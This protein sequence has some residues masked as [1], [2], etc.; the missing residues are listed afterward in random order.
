MLGPYEIL[1]RI[2]AGGMG[3]VF[4]ARDTR[5]DRIV[6]IKRLKPE[7]AERFKR[8]ARAIAQLNHPHICQ[9]YDVGEDYLVMEF[10]DG[11]PLPSRLP[12]EDF[13]KLAIQIAAALEEAHTKGI[14]H[15]DLKPANILVAA[16]GAKLL[17]FGLA[18]F[19]KPLPETT[20]TMTQAG[21][22]V[23][24]VAYMSPEQAQ[25]LPIDTRSD[26]FSLGAVLYEACSGSR[27]F[28]GETALATL[29][30]IIRDDP[31]DLE[32]SPSLKRIIL[33]CLAKQTHARYQTM[34]DLRSALEQLVRA[35][36]QDTQ[37]SIAVL[38]FANMSPEADEYFSDGLAEEIINLLAHIP[39]LKVTARTSAF[40]FR[41]KEQ[42]IRKIADA[43]GVRAILEGSVRR[44]GNR[45][46]VTAQLINATDGLHLWSER[47]DRELTD[48]FA[49]QDEIARAITD[50]LEV[51]LSPDA[52]ARRRHTPPLPAYEAFLKGRHQMQKWTAESMAR[53]SQCYLEA[54]ELDP[55]FALAHCELGLIYFCM[56]TDNVIPAAQAAERMRAEAVRALAIDP[57]L[58]EPH[59]VLALVAIL[60]YQW[61]EAGRQFRLAMAC[62]PVSPFMRYFYCLFYL[63]PLGKPREA[64]E[65]V[66]QALRTDPLNLL[67]RMARGMFLLA[68]DDSAGEQELLA[69]LEMDET[70]WIPVLWLVLYYRRQG[71]TAEAVAFGGKV[72]SL[73]HTNSAIAGIAAGLL[74]HTDPDHAAT[75]FNTL[76]S[77]E[78]YG[79][80][81]GLYS[82]HMVR[83]EM[84]LAAAWLEKAIQQ[85]DT[86]AP[87]I[88][89]R[90]YGRQFI[91]TP[92]W[93][94]LARLM[95]L[96]ES[97]V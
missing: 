10:I 89:P 52:A 18:K 23:G 3:E 61:E 69:V 67:P 17:D 54:I 81:N 44:A 15:R 70:A 86:R 26:I 75:L 27:P 71:R 65:Q 83:G 14:V 8:E 34:T 53:C 12:R 72:V 42:D 9:L 59:A 80:P 90:L 45:I 79:A 21:T 40:A 25:G 5:V 30:S 35:P 78:E 22:V 32:A 94:R 29:S 51:R 4:K 63:S 39:E 36:R 6:A 74:S 62:G 16:K 38:P 93:P 88:L 43:L 68:S 66:E 19:Q 57:S 73:A 92:H 58:A 13:L 95:N 77:G 31:P 84:D 47:Y 46:R 33:R 41:G 55:Q 24:T 7:H 56:T 50:A 11:V 49:I 87:W 48:V 60:D 2:G 20:V 28:Q 64:L 85:R 82:Y 91:S 37:P 97:A 76:G 1:A 96:P